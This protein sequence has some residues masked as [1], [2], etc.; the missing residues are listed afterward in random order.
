MVEPRL[1]IECQVIAQVVTEKRPMDQIAVGALARVFETVGL[2]IFMTWYVCGPH[3]LLNHLSSL[4]ETLAN[5]N[6]G[7][8]PAPTRSTFKLLSEYRHI[9]RETDA[10]DVATSRGW[11]R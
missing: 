11:G 7:S 3:D 5:E 4:H 9:S 8:A 2:S 6:A 10:R 1:L